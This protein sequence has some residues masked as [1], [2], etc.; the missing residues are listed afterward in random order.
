MPGKKDEHRFALLFNLIRLRK[1]Q[2]LLVF[3]TCR[4]S[5]VEK[6][7]INRLK[8]ELSEEFSFKE[9]G[10]DTGDYL[11]I[12]FI[13]FS[14]NYF[15]GTLYIICRFPFN[16]F[17]KKPA[18]WEE[19]L[20]RLVSGLNISRD[21]ISEKKLKIVMIC[22]PELEILITLKAPDFYRFKNFSA[23]FLEGHKLY[24]PG[25]KKKPGK[26]KKN[27]QPKI[28]FLLDALKTSPGEEVKAEIYYDLGKIYYQLS[29]M[30]QALSYLQ[31][32]ERIYRKY[33]NTRIYANVMG[34]LG[35]I[36]SES[37]QPEKAL[38]YLK[39]VLTIDQKTGYLRGKAVSLG[40][41]GLV[42]QRLA[43]VKE[44]LKYLKKSG[45]IFQELGVPVPGT[46]DKQI[47][48]LSMTKD[49]FQSTKLK[50]KDTTTYIVQCTYNPDHLF[51]VPFEIE[52]GPKGLPKEVE[53]LCPFCGTIMPVIIDKEVKPDKAV[54]R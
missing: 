34:N 32:A 31:K 27:I 11:P 37:E 17:Y 49:P 46:F 3:L 51:P 25:D 54:L 20:R 12:D 8:K 42:Y 28:D 18:A 22:P 26:D 14:E 23:S 35:A 21:H 7:L 10:F 4:S 5:H 53:A 43:Q 24:I 13:A 40:N 2:G 30:D 9:L 15:P 6:S 19:N 39:E 29:Q 44:A 38:K 50:K 52:P 36:Y 16:E 1:T 47:K 45:K 41:I 33:K 48:I